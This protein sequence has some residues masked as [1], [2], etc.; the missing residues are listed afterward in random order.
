MVGNRIF[1]HIS[2]FTRYVIWTR[3]WIVINWHILLVLWDSV[4]LRGLLSN[5]VISNVILTWRKINRV[6]SIGWNRSVSFSIWWVTKVASTVH[7]IS[8]IIVISVIC[9][10]AGYSLVSYILWSTSNLEGL[11]MRIV[12][13]IIEFWA[14]YFIFTDEIAS[15]FSSF[16]YFSALNTSLNL[17][18]WFIVVS[19]SW[20][21]VTSWVGSLLTNREWLWWRLIAIMV[22]RTWTWLS[23][24]LRA[25]DALSL[26]GAHLISWWLISLKLIVRLIEAWSEVRHLR[27]LLLL[28]LYFKW[29]S[30]STKFFASI[31]L[32]WSYL[33]L[34]LI[35]EVVS[36]A[37]L[38][39]KGSCLRGV[40]SQIVLWI[41]LPRWRYLLL[42]LF[43]RSS[44]NFECFRVITKFLWRIISSWSRRH[45]LP[46]LSTLSSFTHIK[47]LAAILNLLVGGVIF[48]GARAVVSVWTISALANLKAF[49]VTSNCLILMV[50]EA[51]THT[52]LYYNVFSLLRFGNREC[53]SS[54]FN[55][56]VWWI[57]LSWS[58]WL[59]SQFL[60]SLGSNC[61]LIKLESQ[62]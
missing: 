42:S 41:V 49:R 34:S 2:D 35:D 17:F 44:L 16:N 10:W 13:N 45:F 21:V 8:H 22:I 55:N 18:I 39:A 30:I 7:W 40:F 57:V 9:S 11:H 31:I 29:F 62:N 46:S 48:A 4:H 23:Q 50:V 28:W 26:C 24:F 12:L 47:G 27:W 15:L 60:F 1:W 20:V 25:N 54:F 32:S 61:E 51:R 36:T 19:W 6:V 59:W 53:S 58:W 14:T 3:T 56:W 38:L 43:L 33:W 52:I 5:V 37:S